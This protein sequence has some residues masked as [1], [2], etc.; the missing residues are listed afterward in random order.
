MIPEKFCWKTYLDLNQDLLR[1]GICKKHPLI[2]HFLNW[3]QNEGRKYKYDLPDDF[4]WETYLKLNPDLIETGIHKKQSAKKHYF[5]YGKHEGRLYKYETPETPETPVFDPKE[6]FRKIC[7]ENMNYIR[8]IDLPEFSENSFFESVFIEYRCF[9]HSEFLIRNTIIKLGEKWSHTVVCGNLNY[10]YMVNMCSTISN[11]IKIIKTNFDNLFPSQYSAFL[12]SLDFWNLLNG[13]KILIH[14][15]DSIIFKNN[16]EDFLCWDYI[17]APWPQHQNDNNAGVGNGGISLRTKSVMVQIINTI[18]P[19]NTQFNSHTLEYI[20][21]TNSTFPP[22]DVYFSKNM[23]DLGIG[24]LADRITAS[25]FST[26]SVCNKNSFAGHNFWLNDLDWKNR[27]YE[28]NVI[29]FKNTSDS[30]V[31]SI[32]HR[33]GWK[34]VIDSLINANFYNKSSKIRFYDTVEIGFLINNEVCFE[35]W[36][37]IIHWVPNTPNHLT[38]LDINV[39]FEK[40]NFIESLKTCTYI[41]TLSKYLTKYI[42]NKFHDMNLSIPVYTLK[43]PVVTE[44]IIPFNYE[45]Y[46]NN[47]NK[48]LIQIGQQL[49]KV[50][51]IYLLNSLNYEKMWLTGCKDMNHANFLLQKELENLNIDK[52]KF[53]TNVEMTY[54]ETFSH[55]DWLLS[56]NVVFVDLFDAGANN[57]VLECIVRNTPIIINKIEPVVEY[58]GHGYPLYFNNLDEVPFLLSYEK[59]LEAHVYLRNMDKHDLSMGFFTK[60][61]ININNLKLKKLETTIIQFKPNYRMDDLEHRGGWKTIIESLININFYNTNAKIDFLDVVESKFL[62]NPN[63]NYKC[64]NKWCG[65]LH[66]TYNTPPHLNNL[67]L[68]V[69]FEK[70]N[71]IESLKTCTYIITLSKY[72]TKYIKNKFHD[73]NLSIP[74]YTLKHPVVTENIIPFNYE[75]YKNNSNKKLIQIGQ[76]LRKV[77]SIY[78]LNSLNYEKMWLTGCK[79]MN[80]A[81]FLL[82]KELENLNIDKNKF[83]TNVEMTYTE[84]FSHYDWLLSRNVVF[85]DLFDAGANNTVLECIVRNTPIIINKIEPVVE[86]LGDGYPLYF[87]NLD[88]VPFLLS[89]EKI[90]EAHVYLCNIDKNDLS[91]DLFI[92]N[93]LTLTNIETNNS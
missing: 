62:W 56:R 81:N 4:K 41:I 19:L 54:T 25:D 31:N 7:L 34:T 63:T 74:V 60:A 18:H 72:L 52:N 90:L 5:Y 9:P 42:K 3:G 24:L 57:T 46:K 61:L 67:N 91:I 82:Q 13:E 38:Y 76:Q 80:H 53:I 50:S 2:N 86:Y 70:P 8:F 27:I 87:N 47:S 48:K 58:L 15:E 65:I 51:S 21:N 78:L 11:K 6:E 75:E 77:S 71:F 23:E 64:I 17:G 79:D 10:E 35:K 49:R 39:M 26:E 73:M 36:C 84:T 28:N 92:K 33:G 93:L 12:T 68:N 40:P 88:E 32:T 59:I 14:Q 55:Y 20:K 85:V 43:H 83:I 37:G 1:A 69:M 66:C 30:Y 44:N 16:I 29:Q 22:E 89:D 45:E